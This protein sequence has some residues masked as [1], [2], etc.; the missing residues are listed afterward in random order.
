MANQPQKNLLDLSVQCLMF[1]KMTTKV[2]H[3]LIDVNLKPCPYQTFKSMSESKKARGL[4][5]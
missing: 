4:T 1:C 5:T 2:L 3:G